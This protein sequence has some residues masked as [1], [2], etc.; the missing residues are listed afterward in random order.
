MQQY[1][2]RESYSQVLLPLMI[3]GATQLYADDGAASIA[4]GGIVVMK[5]ET[6]ITMAKE[7]LQ[8]SPLEG[9]RRL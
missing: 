2:H 1:P 5:R 8:I 9:D 6:R 4:A 7:V 3:M